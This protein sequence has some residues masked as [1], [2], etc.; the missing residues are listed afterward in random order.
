MEHFSYQR[1]DIKTLVRTS[2]CADTAKSQTKNGFI[3]LVPNF[4][5]REPWSFLKI[6]VLNFVVRDTGYVERKSDLKAYPQ[7]GVY[8]TDYFN[9]KH[10]SE[11]RL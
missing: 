8:N 11:N 3:C 4:Q 7:S 2:H 10:R 6:G 1:K 5:M 9:Y